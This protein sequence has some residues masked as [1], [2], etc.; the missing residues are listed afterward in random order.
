LVDCIAGNKIGPVE[1]GMPGIPFFGPLNGPSLGF[2]GV[3]GQRSHTDHQ[4]QNQQLDSSHA[5]FWL[6]V[7]TIGVLIFFALIAKKSNQ[8]TKILDLGSGRNPKMAK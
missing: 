2:L 5:W 6:M 7:I 8:D 4:G 3:Y 1:P